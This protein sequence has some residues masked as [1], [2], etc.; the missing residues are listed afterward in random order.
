[1][2][3][4]T[5]SCHPAETVE[6]AQTASPQTEAAWLFWRVRCNQNELLGQ[7]GKSSES[8]CPVQRIPAQGS[9]ALWP[10]RCTYRDY[11]CFNMKENK[12]DPCIRGPYVWFCERDEASVINSP[13]PTRFYPCL[14]LV[15]VRMISVSLD[16]IKSRLH[17]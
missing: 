9:G 12:Q 8:L 1:M 2:D 13:R 7:C 5:S 15:K 14:R 3:S 6:E 17:I 16:C 11:F 10:W 4:E